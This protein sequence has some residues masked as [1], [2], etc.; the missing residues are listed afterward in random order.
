ME[1]HEMR[2]RC[3]EAAVYLMIPLVLCASSLDVYGHTSTAMSDP[4]FGIT[5]DSKTVRFETMPKQLAIQCARLRGRYSRAWVFGHFKSED[6][7]YYLISGLMD[8]AK[9]GE[10]GNHQSIVPDEGGGVIVAVKG[11]EC[12]Q[13]QSEYFF[14][15]TT[16]PSKRATP[17]EASPSVLKGI[18]QDA[19]ERYTQAFGGRAE[20]L[21]HVKPKAI[22][23]SIIRVEFEKFAGENRP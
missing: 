5:Y 12:T 15:Q 21:R 1:K 23:P 18:L 22:G 11:S 6:S 16:N 13:D 2:N 7:E 9:K 4:L 3:V 14:D 20:F 19:F 10:A 8:L 17:I